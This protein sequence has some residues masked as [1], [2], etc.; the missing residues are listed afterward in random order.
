MDDVAKLP[1]PPGSS[2]WPYLGELPEFLKDGYGFV[3]T[4]T[5]KYGP[6][7]R[8]KIL[9]RPAAVI[10]GA[11]ASG[12]F[13]DQKLVQR[14]GAMPSHIQTLFGGRALP[15]LDGDEHH[16]RKA[17]IMSAFTEE[18]L[19]G[20]LPT[21][22]TLVERSLASWATGQEISWLA[23][24]KRLAIE[25]ICTTILGLPSGPVVDAV[26]RDYE[27]IVGGFT[28]LPVPLPGSAFSRAKAALARVLAVY[29]KNVR[30]RLASPKTSARDGLDHILAA[31]SARDGRQISVD[32]AKMELHHIVVAGLIVWAWF[33]T[34]VRELEL[35]P[36]VR[37]R[38][39]AE[40]TA[41]PRVLTLDALARAHELQKVTMEL[42]RLSPVVQVFFG[43]ARED[44]AFKGHRVP[45]GWMVLW[46]IRSSHLRAETYTNP[47]AFDPERFSEARHE[48]TRHEHAF[49]PNGAGSPT[50]GHKCAGWEFAP[51]FLQTFV[52]ELLRGGYAWTF[53][54][55][56]DLSLDMSKV[57]P[58]PRGG[59][60]AK[61]T[62]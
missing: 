8:T 23:G 4:R 1:L 52:V 58:P 9:G 41:L 32:E 51:M 43:Q 62:R 45:R 26:A 38:L 14:S 44:F 55:G 10:S 11:D 31:R 42:R 28:S 5:Q 19:A 13:V 21:L 18:A 39:R 15:V 56:Q 2:G 48:Q 37:E 60:M 57:P 40:V 54:P 12:L 50:R 49:V 61:L 6:I 35:H 17:F 24:F 53:T 59:L 3:E 36:D 27:I 30:E 33:V 7:F 34:S 29:E 22:Q 16:E 20:Y 25:G 47:E 46:G